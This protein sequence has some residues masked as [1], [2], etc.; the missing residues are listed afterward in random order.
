MPTLATQIRELT[1]FGEAAALIERAARLSLA[2]EVMER[3]IELSK[4]TE[5]DTCTMLAEGLVKLPYDP[6]WLEFNIEI[7]S[8]AGA[9]PGDARMGVLI[10]DGADNG[11][12]RITPFKRDALSPIIDELFAVRPGAGGVGRFGV[13]TETETPLDPWTVCAYND[14]I[15]NCVCAVALL[16]A[17]NAPLDIGPMDDIEKL[18]RVRER[19]GRTPV[20]PCRP[21]RWNLTRVLRHLGTVTDE[22]RRR[23]VAHMVRGH[24]RR[25]YGKIFWVRPHFR[26]L[27]PGELSPSGKEYRVEI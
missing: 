3:V 17:Y 5:R 9:K 13:E 2:D 8:A 7:A 27:A 6:L 11:A 25:A 24:L 16:T 21:V 12:W 18:N 20:L 26:C 23:A 4:S 14:L 15:I 19:R 22:D 10:T 1:G